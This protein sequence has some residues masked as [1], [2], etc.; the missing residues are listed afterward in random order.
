M[1]NFSLR[2][3]VCSAFFAAVLGASVTFVRAA[4][5]ATE[6]ASQAA[7]VTVFVGTYTRGESKGIYRCQLDLKTGRLSKPVLAAEMPNPS[8]LAVHPGGKFLYAVSEVGYFGGEKSGSVHAFA[9]DHES[10][11]LKPLN[12]Q[13]SGGTGPCHI[14]I[15]ATA[16]NA[17]VAN[18]GGGSV[19]CLPIQKNGKLKPASSVIQHTGSSVNPRRQ[20]APHA[21]SINLDKEN[22]R[23]VAADLGIDKLL[24]YRFDP[25]K[26]TLAPHDPPAFKLAPGAGPRHFTFHPKGKFAYVINELNLTVTALAY[27]A[28][29]GAFKELQTISTLPGERRA[30]FSTAEVQAHPSGKFLYGSNRGHNTIV[31]YEIDPESGRL[32]LIEHEPT[33]GRTPRNFGIDPTGAYLLAANQ[34]SNSILVCRIDQKTGQ[35]EPVGKPVPVPSPVCVKFLA[36]P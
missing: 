24:V 27:D 15:D 16:R 25:E 13:S 28:D 34:A 9:I 20:K 23:A 4:R 22:R 29:R 35:L 18:Y 19:A 31:C 10:G 26:G 2:P 12:A 8:F 7:R 11:E 1:G 14:V 32:S 36:R 3:V 30:G 6:P 17:L 21:H 5:P 33:Q